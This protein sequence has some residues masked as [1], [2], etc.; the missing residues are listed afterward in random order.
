MPVSISGGRAKALDPLTQPD[1]MLLQL[2][3]GVRAARPVGR[4]EL[5]PAQTPVRSIEKRAHA[6]GTG[7]ARQ[8]P[9]SGI[10]R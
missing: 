8:I 4:H 9:G 1:V 3:C 10:R 5:Q 6:A 2:P 7:S